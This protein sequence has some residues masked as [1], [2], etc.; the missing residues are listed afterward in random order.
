MF[1]AASFV[2]RAVLFAQ[3][4]IEVAPPI[5]TSGLWYD[6][7]RGYIELAMYEDAYACLVC[8]PYERLSVARRPI[9]FSSLTF[10]FYV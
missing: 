8:T 3:M 7:I 9:L 5:D 4:A 1:K 10:N 2:Y 6:V